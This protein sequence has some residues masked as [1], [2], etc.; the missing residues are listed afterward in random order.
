WML[1]ELHYRGFDEVDERR[2]WDPSL[3]A[4]RTEL[5]RA[6][7]DELKAEVQPVLDL[8][9][10]ARTLPA[11][12]EAITSWQSQESLPSFMHRQATAEQYREFLIQRSVYHL[13]ESDPHAW[14][15]PRL[16][17]AAKTALAELQNDE[18]GAGRPEWLHSRLYAEALE[19]AGLDA[20]YGA[21][22]DQ[23]PAYTLAVNNAMSLFGLNRRLRAAAMGHLAAFE[24]TS[25]IPCR[26]Y[27][28]GARRLELGEAVERYFDEHVEADAVHEHL[29]LRGICVPLAEETPRLRDDV[30][31]GAAACILLDAVAG[32]A[33]VAAWR[34]GRSTLAPAPERTAA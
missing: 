6:F 19:A 16:E 10:E 29:A 21:Y 33:M 26:R 24:M 7:E 32:D 17:G 30:L 15:L 18:F 22:V 34:E 13:K 20:A 2:E 5:E 27:L 28:Q 3:I 23:V 1:Y 11:Q 4:V 31:F 14:A 12:V 8:A 9:A 25:S